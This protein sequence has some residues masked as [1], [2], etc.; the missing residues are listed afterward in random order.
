MGQ[1]IHPVG[2]RTGIYL[3][4]ESRWYAGKKDFARLLKEDRQ[5]RDFVRKEFAGAGIPKVEIE[6][7]ADA[8]SVIVHTAK[9]GVLIGRKG[10]KAEDLKNQIEKVTGR[11]VSLDIRDV[12]KPEL[13]ATLVAQGVAEQLVKRAAYRRTLKRAI[14]QTRDADLHAQR[15]E[16]QSEGS[17]P[18]STLKADISYGTATA[19]T[20]Y[21]AIGVKCWVYRGMLQPTQSDAVQGEVV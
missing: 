2:F 3:D 20:T 1:K 14:Q 4:W 11:S 16:K 7:K 17:I 19:F 13:D 6:R 12:S 18:L 15:V 10:V 21:G 9:P 5:I 8:V